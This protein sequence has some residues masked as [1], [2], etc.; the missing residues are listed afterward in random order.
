MH[1]PHLPTTSQW[2][3]YVVKNMIMNNNTEWNKPNY[4][5]NYSDSRVLERIRRGYGAIKAVLHKD[6]PTS[7]SKKW[8]DRNIGSQSNPLSKFLRHQLLICVNHYYSIGNHICKQYVLNE[9]REKCIR[10]IL[11]ANESHTD[12]DESHTDTDE[13][14]TNTNG[15]PNKKERRLDINLTNE[16][17]LREYGDE[18]KNLEF[19]YEHKSNRL[20]H[21]LQQ[22]RKEFKP[23]IFAQNGLRFHYDISACA[24]TLLMQYACNLG[25][26]DESLTHVIDYINNKKEY[27]QHIASE[28]GISNE[29]A[30]TVI[31][32][33]FCG[34]KLGLNSH[35]QL[36]E[37][38]MKQTKDT[39]SVLLAK[40]LTSD[41]RASIKN[42]WKA[43]SETIH[44]TFITDVNG[45]VR[46]QP[47]SSSQ[48]WAI[49][50]QLEEQVLKSVIKYLK[51]TNNRHFTEHDGWSTEKMIDLDDLTRHVRV[52]TGFTIK[53]ECVVSEIDNQNTIANSDS[54][55]AESLRASSTTSLTS[56]FASAQ[57]ESTRN[58]SSST[59]SPIIPISNIV[60]YIRGVSPRFALVSPLLQLCVRSPHMTMTTTQSHTE[61]I[62][63]LQENKPKTTW[64]REFIHK[65]RR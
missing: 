12:T 4:K 36:Y 39:A 43:I 55:T 27:R 28:A 32:A 51:K 1:S 41:L 65:I 17:A 24:P 20:W 18:L 19:T 59:S 63:P 56:S 14:H 60:K 54:D 23:I 11:F 47:I 8:L 35:F 10:E 21:P 48:K 31:N 26:T 22:E 13:S 7:L 30:K 3:F 25:A 9:K 46:K 44:R 6:K 38:I 58:I 53:I 15:F 16:Y 29:L 33:L 2:V 34:A 45:V 61:N 40:D 62:T 52:E 64:L 57:E 42:M 37:Q 50:F 49:Y 5:I